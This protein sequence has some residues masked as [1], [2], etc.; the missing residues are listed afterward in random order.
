MKYCAAK[1]SLVCFLIFLTQVLP[2]KKGI[3]VSLNDKP[4]IADNKDWVKMFV[5][6]EKVHFLDLEDKQGHSKQRKTGKSGR[7]RSK[8]NPS[9]FKSLPNIIFS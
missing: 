7:S 9:S 2:T 5:D 3:W 8:G 1:T 4:L 6:K